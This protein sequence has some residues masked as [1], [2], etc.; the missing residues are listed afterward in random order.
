MKSNKN[1]TVNIKSYLNSNNF[2]IQNKLNLKNYFGA[3][4]GGQTEESLI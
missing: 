2:K 1:M 3:L 4:T